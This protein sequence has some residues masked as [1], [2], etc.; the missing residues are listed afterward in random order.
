MKVIIF[1]REDN[2]LLEEAKDRG[3]ELEDSGVV[4]EYLD[5]E[6]YDGVEQA[7]IYDVYSTPSFVVTRENGSL[8][9][10]WRGEVPILGE[11][12]YNTKI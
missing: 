6:S 1:T 2:Q 7:M 9:K 8:I 10:I 3:K 11:I 12:L 4:V 5:T